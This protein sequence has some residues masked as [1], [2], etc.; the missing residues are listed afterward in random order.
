MT[1]PFEPQV[2]RS[3]GVRKSYRVNILVIRLVLGK[4]ISPA[5]PWDIMSATLKWLVIGLLKEVFV[6]A[7]KLLLHRRHLLGDARA[8]WKLQNMFLHTFCECKT[9][10]EMN[11]K[12]PVNC[13]MCINFCARRQL[14]LCLCWR[15]NARKPPRVCCFSELWL[16][17]CPRW[18]LRNF[19]AFR[20]GGDN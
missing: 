20:G 5:R 12:G 7:T 6:M 1:S 18:K 9:L 17:L 4:A 11:L 8:S 19:W 3:K 13:K 16:R 10:R 15:T 2:F 14:S